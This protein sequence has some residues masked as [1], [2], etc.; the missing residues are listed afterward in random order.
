MLRFG[1]ASVARLSCRGDLQGSVADSLRDPRAEAVVRA[2]ELRCTRCVP[3]C[4]RC[5][6]AAHA[7][8]RR[9]TRC[10]PARTRCVS[11]RTRCVSGRTR[12]V[13]GCTWCVPGWTR[14]VS[15]R[16][17]RVSGRAR[18]VS[19]RA[20]C[21]SGRA[22]CVSGCARC[23]SDRARCVSVCAMP[24]R[25]PHLPPLFAART[26]AHYLRASGCRAG[27]PVRKASHRSQ[28]PAPHRRRRPGAQGS[29]WDHGLRPGL[30]FGLYCGLLGHSLTLLDREDVVNCRPRYLFVASLYP[31][32]NA[33]V[34]VSGERSSVGRVGASQALGRGFESRRSLQP[35][36]LHNTLACGASER[37]RPRAVW[38]G[39][40]LWATGGRS[41]AGNA[42]LEVR[43]STD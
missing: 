1:R 7:V 30:Y 31:A 42:G 38:R 21:V 4:K 37:R 36:T 3:V 34:A 28:R 8:Y 16:T 6:T 13:S 12:C 15:G 40:V 9:C 23:V 33:G 19:G 43:C 11:G 18:C 14:C 29:I 39:T 32:E 26:S 24:H 22:R 20:R 17:R 2:G 35:Q 25:S 27:S 10:G 5:V 41:K